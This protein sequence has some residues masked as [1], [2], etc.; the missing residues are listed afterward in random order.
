MNKKYNKN[1]FSKKKRKLTV[2]EMENG[3]VINKYRISSKE[4]FLFKN[5]LQKKLFQMTFLSKIHKA[6]ES[7]E[8]L[9]Y[10]VPAKEDNIIQ[11]SLKIC[12]FGEK[13][14]HLLKEN[15]QPN[16]YREFAKKHNLVELIDYF[17][18][19]IIYNMVQS[20][21]MAG[22]KF[23]EEDII[24]HNLDEHYILNELKSEFGSIYLKF[25]KDNEIS[26]HESFFHTEG[27]NFNGLLNKLWD[28]FNN[29]I[30]IS[31]DDDKINFATIPVNK[32]PFCGHSSIWAKELIQKYS[33]YKKDYVPRACLFVGPPGAGKSTLVIKLASQI[34]N[35]TLRIEA[36]SLYKFN[37]SNMQFFLGGLK[38]DCLIIDDVDRARMDND[39]SLLFTILDWMKI[40]Y[41]NVFLFMTANKVKNLDPAFVRPG[42]IDEV[43][44]FGLP[45]KE[46]RTKL[47]QGYLDF[48]N[49]KISKENIDRIVLNTNGLA[50]PWIKE[51]VLQLKYVSVQEVMLLID[52]MKKLKEKLKTSYDDENWI[53][54]DTIEKPLME[55][56]IEKSFDI[57]NL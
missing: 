36:N 25:K 46:D 22:T 21:M 50:V 56:E 3:E 39:L 43:L 47:L 7:C 28:V 38:P 4:T 27:F 49:I 29:R 32:D 55:V 33:K 16:K 54:K 40:Q 53:N 19:S 34:G 11:K 6:L 41:P 1:F 35:R 15:K 2:L 51:I 52:N 45:S 9:Y 24:T 31:L 57:Y 30:N 37:N 18:S 12:A 20:K 13:L 44:W 14:Y 17:L 5:Q 48:Y 26:F 42:R 23:F 10:L 8:E